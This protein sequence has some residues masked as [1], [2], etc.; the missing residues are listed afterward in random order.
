MMAISK[1]DFALLKE[2][3]EGLW[4]AE[5]RF[6]MDWMKQVLAPDFVEFGQSSKIYQRQDTLDIPAQ[7]IKTIIP[8]PDFKVKLI[9][10]N[11]AQVTYVSIVEYAEGINKALRSSIWSRKNG[12]GWQL[13]F[14]QGTPLQKIN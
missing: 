9:D 10:D 2:L 5:K 3:E 6:N 12:D 1:Q 4:I 13:R 8:L 11:I 14:H 7:E